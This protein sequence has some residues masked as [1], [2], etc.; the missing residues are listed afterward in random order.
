MVC[1]T[2]A[3]CQ[4]WI[5]HPGLSEQGDCLTNLSLDWKEFGDA[6]NEKSNRYFWGTQIS[7]QG[8]PTALADISDEE[9]LLEDE[10]EAWDRAHIQIYMGKQPKS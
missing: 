2:K 4:D 1:E 3:S 6:Q 8:R 5:S 7:V 9:K 10:F